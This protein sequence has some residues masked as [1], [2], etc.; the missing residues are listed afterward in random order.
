ML[1]RIRRYSLLFIPLI[2]LFVRTA[3]TGSVWPLRPSSECV[4]PPFDGCGFI[5][6]EAHYI[7][8]VRRMLEGE[9]VNL[10]HPP[11]SKWLVILGILLLGDSPYGWRIPMV[12]ASTLTLM[13]VGLLAKKIGGE[14]CVIPAQL[15]LFTD[16]TFFNIG[17][18]AVLDPPALL[19]MV[20][21]AYLYVSGMRFYAGLAAGLSMLSKSSGI[22]L[23]PTLMVLDALHE[24]GKSRDL[25][26]AVDALRR[27]VRL[28]ALPAL[29]VFFLG[30]AVWDG[31]TH[32]FPT[33]L[34]HLEFMLRYHS[35]LRYDEPW[36]VELPLS[37]IIPPITRTP[38]PYFVETVSPPGYHPTA[39]WGVSSPLWWSVWLAIPLAYGSLKR[40]WMS[41]PSPEAIALGWFGLNFAAFAYLAYIAKRWTYSF[42]FLQISP[43]L[44]AMIPV[45]LERRGLGIVLNVMVAAQVLWF[46]MFF[47]S[48]PEWLIQLLGSL[49]LGEA[50]WI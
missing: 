26:G 49:G 19:F 4:D 13:V 25:D 36:R 29:L 14:R 44:A 11:L 35:G 48:K 42:Y 8:A 20:L 38:A 18:I 32:A 27:G 5:F 3:L 23:I 39:F 46:I 37:W 9:A 7:P 50:P 15:L 31:Q 34:H 10:E 2:Y 33:P 17:G 28:Y 6:D 40:S 24:Y 47:P 12:I 16:V 43:I 45:I 1:G 22:L 21:A 30:V 41:N